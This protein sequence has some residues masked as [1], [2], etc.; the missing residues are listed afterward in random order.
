MHNYISSY[1]ITSGSFE[2][3]GV[4]VV[5]QQLRSWVSNPCWGRNTFQSFFSNCIP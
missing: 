2:S 3:L 1:L 4:C 5:D